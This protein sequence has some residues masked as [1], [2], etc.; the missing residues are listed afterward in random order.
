MLPAKLRISSNIEAG[1][2]PNVLLTY[3]PQTSG[4]LSRCHLRYA[5]PYKSTVRQNIL[6]L[7]RVDILHFG[8]N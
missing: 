2:G 4:S 3:T 8:E 7:S 1:V 5:L 6:T